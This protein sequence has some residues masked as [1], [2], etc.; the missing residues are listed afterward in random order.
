MK[1]KIVETDDGSHSL[2]I[3][4]LDESYHSM[5]GAVNES[6]HV[7]INAGL[8]ILPNTIK[9]INLLEIGFGTGLNALLTFLNCK[10][11]QTR[12]NYYS[13]EPYPLLSEIYEQ[14][15]YPEILGKRNI[16]EIFIQMHKSEWNTEVN[17]NKY[18]SLKKMKEKLESINLPSDFYHLV[19]FDAFA[20][21]VNPELWVQDI[22][23]KIYVSM[24]T[25][26]VFVTYS[27]K[28]AVRRNLQKS[29]FRVERIPGPKGKREMLRAVKT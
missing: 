16:R 6:N 7:F 24:I 8:N 20:P 9:I 1:I 15:N 28:G 11:K 2:F 5:F 4:E 17:L 22:F 14:L 21:D 29:G 19:Y 18:F 26:G 27:A 3:R 23:D 13:I 10:K 25:D 12:V